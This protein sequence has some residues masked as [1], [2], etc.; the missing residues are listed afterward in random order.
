MAEKRERDICERRGDIGVLNF[1]QGKNRVELPGLIRLTKRQYIAHHEAITYPIMQCLCPFLW[2][3]PID[4]HRF[5]LV[6]RVVF[7]Q[8]VGNKS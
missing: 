7:R 4:D 1:V 6:G 8:L 5:R 3:S 2:L